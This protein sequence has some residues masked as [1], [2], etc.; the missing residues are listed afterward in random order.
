MFRRA[1]SLGAT[2]ARDG[3]S[4]RCASLLL[5]VF[6]APYHFDGSRQ[7]TYRVLWKRVLDD[8]AGDTRNSRVISQDL[9]F[10]RYAG[11]EM[12]IFA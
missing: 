4:I 8:D 1:C 2:I 11:D 5:A 10:D 7:R 6:V 3:A 9:P 12:P